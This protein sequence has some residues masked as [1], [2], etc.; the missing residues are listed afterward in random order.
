MI[1]PYHPHSLHVHTHPVT[2]IL[3]M[4]TL[5]LSPPFFTCT[6]SPCH[7]HSLHVHTHPVT[8]SFSINRILWHHGLP[9]HYGWPG[10]TRCSCQGRFHRD[11][12]HHR[13]I[14]WSITQT[15]RDA[16][17]ATWLENT[18]NTMQHEYV[19]KILTFHVTT[20]HDTWPYKSYP[21][22]TTSA[23]IKTSV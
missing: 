6:H 8:P 23:V 3:Y 15:C 19:E 16:M 22:K 2:P 17:R 14:N 5:N 10:C 4:H 13:V 1:S 9:T 21:A 20:Q 18:G 12:T 7:P 11:V